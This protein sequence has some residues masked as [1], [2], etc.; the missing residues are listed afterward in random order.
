[1]FV[2]GFEKKKNQVGDASYETY[3]NERDGILSSLARRA[4]VIHWRHIKR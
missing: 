2:Y 1:L 4:K 3:I